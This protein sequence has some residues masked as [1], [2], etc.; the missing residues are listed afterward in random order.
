EHNNFIIKK[1]TELTLQL[2]KNMDFSDKIFFLKETL[3][4]PL[5][6]YLLENPNI[7]DNLDDEN[8]LNS[9][10][11]SARDFEDFFDETYVL[12]KKEER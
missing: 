6:R 8:Y 7:A 12:F 9:V 11:E 10:Y 5:F 3:I 1:V 4:Y 2:I